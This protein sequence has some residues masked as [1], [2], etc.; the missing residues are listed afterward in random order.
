M[1]KNFF[2][3]NDDSRLNEIIFEKRN[4]EYGAYALRNEESVVLAKSLVIGVSFVFALAI[5]PV[6]ANSF[7]A[8][9]VPDRAVSG[10]H[11]LTPIYDVEDVVPDENQ[12][13]TQKKV[14]TFVATVP[15]PTKAVVVETAAPTVA[16]YDKAAPGFE[17][18]EGEKPQNTY[19]PPVVQPGPVTV[20]Y[21]APVTP[22]PAPTVDPNAVMEKVDVQAIFIGGLE[23]FRAKV[24]QNMDISEFAG[25]GEKIT[26]DVTFI[27]EKDGSI[28]NIKASGKDAQFNREA[29]RAVKSVRGK[30]SAAKVK[31]TA[32]RSYFNIPVTVQFE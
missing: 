27:V 8:D 24:G 21:T 3:P 17:K 13:A 2:N 28:S 20:P 31:G 15:K 7:K 30:W 1:M 32:V 23:K 25:S 5:T 10:P 11:D 26:A 29:E 19:T 9:V 12:V 14:E 16:D 6:I 4:K 22:V 18:S